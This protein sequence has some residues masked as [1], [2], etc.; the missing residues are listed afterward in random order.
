M[1]SSSASAVALYLA[2]SGVGRLTLVDFD[3]VEINNLQRQVI[4]RTADIGRPKVASARDAIAA[5]NPDVEVEAIN[6]Q[7]DGEALD[8]A[9]AAAD[10]VLD[11][12]DNF[13]T[14]FAVNA[15]CVRGRRPLVSAAVVRCEGQVSVFHGE[16][17]DAP[18]YRCLY[19]DEGGEGEN[20]TLTGVLAPV[21]GIIGTVQAT[22]AVKVLL[23]IGQTLGGRVLLLDAL[24]MEWRSL[25][26]RKDPACPVCGGR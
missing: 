3:T 25:R 19:R 14:R 24:A 8:A 9:V 21:V 26:L 17:D 12:S 23:G 5:L 18:C 22:E 7:L 16:R 20:C 10:V 15:A 13:D 11:C 1:P 4:H 2:A 6:G